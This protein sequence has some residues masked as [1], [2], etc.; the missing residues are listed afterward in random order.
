L[1]LLPTR[2]V[3]LSAARWDVSSDEACNQASEEEQLE[4]IQPF[5]AKSRGVSR[6]DDR[7]VLSGIIYVQRHGLRWVDVPSAYGP[8]KTLYNRCRRWSE[9]GIFQLIFCEL[10]RS[11]DTGDDTGPE[12]SAGP[13]AGVELEE[14]VLMVAGSRKDL[15]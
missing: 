11:D 7:K 2:E 12:A 10:A 14:E 6:V 15:E 1:H 8:Y 3:K 13:G 5:F 9:K 4:R